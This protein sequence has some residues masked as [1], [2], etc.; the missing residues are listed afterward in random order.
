M[1]PFAPWSRE[2]WQERRRRSDLST[3]QIKGMK[4]E[5]FL[6]RCIIHWCSWGL[7]QSIFWDRRLR[8]FHRP[9]TCEQYSGTDG[10]GACGAKA[11]AVA[12]P[13][14]TAKMSQ[15]RA[16]ESIGSQWRKLGVPMHSFCSEISWKSA[17]W[18]MMHWSEERA[19][20]SAGLFDGVMTVKSLK[21]GQR[22]TREYLTWKRSVERG[23]LLTAN[24]VKLAEYRRNLMSFV[25]LQ[26][27]ME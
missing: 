4:K 12:P 13:D 9:S 7:P 3:A 6:C 19:W 23:W 22:W 20:F 2:R 25:C 18:M 24:I 26:K 21:K 16:H 1:P 27:A 15:D 11:A 17:K 14:K 5:C 8:A 10:Q